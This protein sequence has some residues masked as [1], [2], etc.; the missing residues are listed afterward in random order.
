MGS[1][2]E[3]GRTKLH[4]PDRWPVRWP[5]SSCPGGPL[6][7]GRVLV[8]RPGTGGNVALPAPARDSPAGSSDDSADGPLSDPSSS[9]ARAVSSSASGAT[10]R[11]REPGVARK[12]G[13]G[14]PRASR[15]SDFERELPQGNASYGQRCAHIV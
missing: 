7:V 4:V 12:G 14:G 9:M 8:A 2:V 13:K 6:L 15:T 11:P 10:T 1:T 5:P 3:A